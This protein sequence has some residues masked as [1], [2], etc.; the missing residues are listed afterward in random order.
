MTLKEIRPG[1]NEG[2][3][4]DGAGPRSRRRRR[5]G[6]PG[7]P[8][9]GRL[10]ERALPQPIRTPQRVKNGMSAVVAPQERERSNVGTGVELGDT[11]REKCR[12]RACVRCPRHQCL[13]S[14]RCGCVAARQTGSWREARA[15]R[16]DPALHEPRS[17]SRAGQPGGPATHVRCTQAQQRLSWANVRRRMVKCV[18]VRPPSRRAMPSRPRSR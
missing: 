1:S 13:P 12:R 5:R 10:E 3:A 15:R 16:L 6:R 18:A 2:P 8:D 7:S 11:R 17:V 4:G 14:R 9:P